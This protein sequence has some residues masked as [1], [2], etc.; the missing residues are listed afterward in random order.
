MFM[1]Y[2]F[3]YAIIKVKYFLK[4][5][6]SNPPR[7]LTPR[8]SPNYC[9]R[10]QVSLYL[11]HVKTTPY[12]RSHARRRRPRTG[13]RGNFAGS[14]C[15]N[16]VS[17]NQAACRTNEWCAGAN[18]AA[19]RGPP[20]GPHMPILL[21]YLRSNIICLE[22]RELLAVFNNKASWMTANITYSTTGHCSSPIVKRKIAGR[23]NRAAKL[24]QT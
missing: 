11:S 15:R 8:W 22:P 14:L 5:S 10:W 18:N 20:H 19:P 6:I 12:P 23:W 1:L 7:S 24:K 3:F 2:A 21:K 13:A 16:E 9:D 4:L 17:I